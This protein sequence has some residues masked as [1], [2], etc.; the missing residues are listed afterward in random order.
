MSK[1][2]ELKTRYIIRY[3]DPRLREHAAEVREFDSYLEELRGRMA[4][5]MREEKGVGLAAT[6]L[7]LPFRVV[8]L[9]MTGEAEDVELF[10]NPAIL[11]RE[12]R[13]MDQEGC[14]SV[15]GIF[16][17]VRRAERVRVRTM[18]ANGDVVEME[19]EGLLAR[20]WQHEIDHLEGGLF[21]DRVGPTSKILLKP[22]L[23]ELEEEYREGDEPEGD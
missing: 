3:P 6:Q 9:S 5:L 2:P 23:R 4:E 10:V 17:K 21:I 14:L 18:T 19:A 16:A 13:I 8:L 12:G 1:R 22:R 20:A 15:P 7:G 11:E